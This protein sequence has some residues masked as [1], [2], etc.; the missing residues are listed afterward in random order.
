VGTRDAPFSAPRGATGVMVGVLISKSFPAAGQLPVV[1]GRRLV[2]KRPSWGQV[3]NEGVLERGLP[4]GASSKQG[5]WPCS[6]GYGCRSGRRSTPFHRQQP[7]ASSLVTET[8][9]PPMSSRNRGPASGMEAHPAR[10]WLPE[11][12]RCNEIRHHRGHGPRSVH[13]GR[14]RS[15]D[16]AGL[17]ATSLIRWLEQRKHG[18]RPFGGQAP[19]QADAPS[20]RPRRGSRTVDR[21]VPG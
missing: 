7:P 4:G 21:L 19:Q 16:R 15:D 5:R 9:G 2:F 3:S 1:R 13:S 6:A 18:W 11:G 8:S 10:L 17:S 12:R 14:S 20:G